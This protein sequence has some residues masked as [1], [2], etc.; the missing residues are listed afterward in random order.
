MRWPCGERLLVKETHGRGLKLIARDG[1]KAVVTSP[2]HLKKAVLTD[3]KLIAMGGEVRLGRFSDGVLQWLGADLRS[4]EQVMLPQGQ[5]L[6][7]YVADDEGG[8]WALQRESKYMH[9]IVIG[10]SRL[11]KS[12]EKVKVATGTGLLRDPVLGILLLGHDR[13]TQLSEG[14]PREL[15]L[16]DVVDERVGRTGGVRK[17][18]FHR[19]STTDIDRDGYDDLIAYDELEHRLTVLADRDGVLKVKIAWPVFDDKVYPYSNESDN[20]VREPRAVEAADLDGDGQQDL[21]IICD[22]R[23][24]LYLAREKF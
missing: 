10:A 6:A 20:L 19:L 15:K 18:R 13:V 8:G 21:A 3:F 14:R 23:L 22:D 11:S 24:I 17:T 7:D 5:E 9:R 16:R 4:Y 2:T 12:V 1:D